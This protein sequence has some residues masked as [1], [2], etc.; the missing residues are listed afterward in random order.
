[1]VAQDLSALLGPLVARHGGSHFRA[2][3]HRD[4]EDAFVVSF[5]IPT[6]GKTVQEALAIGTEA[7]A[8]VK[9]TEGDGL[10]LQTAVDL[11]R[12][13]NGAALIGRPEG[14]W[15][16]GKAAP[17]VLT[18]DAKKWELAKDVAAFANSPTGGVIFIGAKTKSGQDGDVVGIR[19]GDRVGW[20]ARALGRRGRGRQD[21]APAPLLRVAGEGGAGPLG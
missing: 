4:V 8:L 16:D 18:S 14:P 17:Y 5:E 21:D 11:I 6:R 15:F 1:V 2:Q 20:A 7:F 12:A 19:G 13:G 9:A 3:R 10:T